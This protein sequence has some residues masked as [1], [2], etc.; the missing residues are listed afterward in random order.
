MR[1]RACATRVPLIPGL[2]ASAL[3]AALPAHAAELTG[4]LQVSDGDSLQLGADDV[5]SHSASGFALTVSGAGSHAQIAGSHIKVTGNGSAVSAT[6]GGQVQLQGATLSI[7][8]AT[9]VGFYAL[10]ASGAG[11]VIDAHDVDIDGTHNGSG[12]A[13]V[14][15]YNGGVLRYR[16]GRIT[17]SG[18]VGTLAGA[19][20][21]GSEVHLDNLQMSAG[22][23][24]RL[25]AESAG[26]LTIRN[27]RITLAP[28]GVLAGV[29]VDGAGSR[30]ELYDTRIDGGWFDIGGGGSVLLENVQADSVGGSLRLLGS[31]IARVHSSAVIN[32]GRFD[33][34]GGYGVNVNSWGQLT[35]DGTHFTVRDGNSGIWLSGADSLADLSNTVISTFGDTGYGHGVDVWGGTATITGGSIDTHGDGVYGLRAS[36][37]SPP[38]PYSRIRARNVDIATYGAASGGVFLGGSTADVQLDGGSIS[39]HGA[40]SFGIVQMNTARLTADDLRIHAQGANSG[41]YRSYITVF[42]PYWDRVVFNNSQIE[43]STGAAFWLQGSNHALSVNGSDVIA[44][45]GSGRLLRVSDTVFTD[46]SRV[47]TSRIDFSADASTLRGDVVVDSATAD[48]HMVLRNNT[49][50][51]GALRDESGFRV[52]RLALDGSSQWNVRASSSVSTLEHAGSIVFDAPAS[53]AFKTITVDGDY[54]G[55]GGH[56]VFNRALGDDASLGDQLVIGGNSSGTASVSVRNAGGAGALTWKASA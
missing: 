14:Q 4:P 37:S 55:Q 15:A 12:Y 23:G 8:P 46:G 9:G 24:A 20:G 13:S 50:F 25:R 22:S 43:T 26:L 52:A 7:A 48:V 27:S 41:A 32:G 18:G 16:G 33:T 29:A 30:A 56:W 21:N 28:G 3:C 39:T 31:S 38:T 1:P 42:G 45:N 17:V 19:S 51:S 44:G 54:V 35:A 2:L 6:Q 47:A 36:G 11:S 40:S 5:L 53:G 34:V 49:R 10:Y